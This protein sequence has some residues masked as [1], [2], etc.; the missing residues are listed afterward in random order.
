MSDKVRITIVGMGAI[1][2]SIGMA[3]KKAKPEVEITGHDKEHATAGRARKRGAVDRTD[4]NLIS[5][6]ENAD[7]TI[8]ATP[9]AEVKDTLAAAGQYVKSGSLVMDTASVKAP[10]LKWAEESL[11]EGASF[12]GGSPVLFGGAREMDPELFSGTV[13]CL[14]PAVSAS[15]EAVAW[16]SELVVA[17]GA[18][19]FFVDATEHDGLMAA[20][21]HLPILLAASLLKVVSAS[22]AWREVARLAGD[23]FA[24]ATMPVRGDAAAHRELCQGNAQNILR[25]LDLFQAQLAELRQAIVDGDGSVLEEVFE[26]ALQARDEWERGEVVPSPDP[27]RYDRGLRSLF[28]GQR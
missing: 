21:G 23:R 27:M 6:C 25:W 7:A 12:V 18:A 3:L 17:L 8:I 13:F 15:P 28:L 14:C 16:A 19:P 11:A 2:T 5:A 4:W 24:D 1:G 9:V 10:V 20:A 22:T 26:A